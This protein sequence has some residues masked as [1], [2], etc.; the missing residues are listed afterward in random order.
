MVKRAEWSCPTDLKKSFNSAEHIGNHRFVFNISGNDYHLTATIHFPAGT[1][2]ILFLGTLS[3]Y[4]WN[5]Q[6]Y[7]QTQTIGMDS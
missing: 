4:N 1:L 7:N 5:R 6:L 2:Y 3:E